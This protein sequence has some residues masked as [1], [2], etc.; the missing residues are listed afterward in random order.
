MPGL[1]LNQTWIN[2]QN[3]EQRS[4]SDLNWTHSWILSVDEY[5]L[6]FCSNDTSLEIKWPCKIIIWTFA[7]QKFN[8]PTRIN[9]KS[10]KVALTVFLCD[11]L[12]RISVMT[13]RTFWSVSTRLFSFSTKVRFTLITFLVLSKFFASN[14]N[15]F[16]PLKLLIFYIYIL[17]FYL[18][19]LS[20]KEI[21][22]NV[23]YFLFVF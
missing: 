18:I 13:T 15:Y 12:L 14:L 22:K 16:Y 10:W 23:L 5:L 3:L 9:D 19:Y 17:N 4:S 20:V 6:Y 2:P 1:D 7:A 11:F 21:Y 8:F